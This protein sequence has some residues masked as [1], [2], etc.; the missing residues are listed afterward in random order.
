MGSGTDLP[1]RREHDEGGRRAMSGF[2]LLEPE[3]EFCSKEELS[4]GLMWQLE[5]GYHVPL[6]EFVALPYDGGIILLNMDYPN[7]QRIREIFTEYCTIDN[8]HRQRRLENLYVE[9]RELTSQSNTWVLSRMRFLYQ[10]RRRDAQERAEAQETIKQFRK[11]RITSKKNGKEKIIK[12]VYD[13]G[14]NEKT[15]QGGT[16]KGAEYCFLYGY[17]SALNDMKN[18][19]ERREKP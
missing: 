11:C 16:Q 1:F 17:L 2:H 14:W 19:E 12:A 15:V 13:I 6:D 9:F 7:I 4:K 8:P 18:Q 10:E 3:F 5:E